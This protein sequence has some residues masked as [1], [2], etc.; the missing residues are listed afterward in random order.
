MQHPKHKGIR[1]GLFPPT[2]VTPCALGSTA[3]A[4]FGGTGWWSVS[5]SA[6][7]G[8]GSDACST[9]PADWES[10]PAVGP[11]VK[12]P[13]DHQWLRLMV[14]ASSFYSWCHQGTWGHQLCLCQAL[15][16]AGSR[17]HGAW[18]IGVEFGQP[19]K[20]TLSLF[21]RFPPHCVCRTPLLGSLGTHTQSQTEHGTIFFPGI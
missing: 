21:F 5:H 18:H 14:L 17:W 13:Q 9:P 19:G 20:V 4:R 10:A 15:A 11:W 16:R 1:L 12:D 8:E 6:M 7:A 2:G 3:T